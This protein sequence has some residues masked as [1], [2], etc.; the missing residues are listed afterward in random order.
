MQK[1]INCHYIHKE[2]VLLHKFGWDHLSRLQKIYCV[3]CYNE[4]N[5]GKYLKSVEFYMKLL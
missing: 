4:V 3:I 5:G 1:N 2:T